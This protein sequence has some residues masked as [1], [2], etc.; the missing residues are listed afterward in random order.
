M[1]S[2]VNISNTSVTLKQSQ[3]HQMYNDYV[4]PKQG[5]NHAKF[6]RSCL[7]MSEK[8]PLFFFSNEDICH[9]S[10][11]NMCKNKKI[12]VKLLST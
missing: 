11:L 10:P 7:K 9:L 2:A 12:L 3:R 6:E 8:K 1:Q 4:D 5:Y